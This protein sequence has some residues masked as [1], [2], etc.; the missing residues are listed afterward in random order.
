MLSIR[1]FQIDTRDESQLSESIGA[2]RCAATVS[3]RGAPTIAHRFAM[4]EPTRG[5]VCDL[6]GQVRGWRS[7]PLV[8]IGTGSYR[9]RAGRRCALVGAARSVRWQSVGGEQHAKRAKAPKQ[10]CDDSLATV[11]GAAP[12]NPNAQIWWFS[13]SARPASGLVPRSGV[14]IND[15]GAGRLFSRSRPALISS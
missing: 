11:G 14:R 10:P 6:F 12:E 4:P 2:D 1:A 5:P 9:A 3:I 13:L 7:H 8:A 15:L